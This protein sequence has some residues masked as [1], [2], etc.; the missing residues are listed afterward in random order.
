MAYAVGAGAL[1]GDVTA[2]EIIRAPGRFVGLFR[3]SM[4]SWLYGPS[5]PQGVTCI[6]SYWPGYLREPQLQPLIGAVKAAGG[7][8]LLRHA[9][10]HAHPEDLRRFVEQAGPRVLLPV[11]TASPELW[12]EFSAATKVVET[13]TNCRDN[14]MICLMQIHRRT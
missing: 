6:F 9:S 2:D 11:H 3:E 12:T 13:R 4:R 1:S 5:L 7:R 8:F 10:G 14:V